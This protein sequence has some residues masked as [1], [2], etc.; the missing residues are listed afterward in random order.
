MALNLQG[1]GFLEV[2]IN[3]RRVPLE[4]MRFQQCLF[5]SHHLFHM[6]M[7]HL[8]FQDTLGILTKVIT[9]ADAVVIR[10][11]I[12]RTRETAKIYDF[13]VFNVQQQP[14]ASGVLY[15]VSFVAPYDR[16]R[17][18]T[19]SEAYSGS[20]YDALQSLAAKCNLRF[21]GDTTQDRQVWL[22]M[23]ETYCKY[24]RRIAATGYADSKSCMLLGLTI[25]GRLRYK[26]LAKIRLDKTVPRITHGVESDIWASGWVSKSKSGFQ[27][28]RGGYRLSTYQFKPSETDTKVEQQ[29]SARRIARNLGINKELK[30]TVGD[31]LKRVLPID[32]G[33]HHPQ[34]QRAWH[35]NKRAVQLLS[36]SGIAVT[37]FATTLDLYDG[38]YFSKYA[39]DSLTGRHLLDQDESGYYVVFGRT[40]FLGSD[41]VYMERFQLT[42]DGHGADNSERTV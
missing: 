10:L 42:R 26:D 21:E 17:L 33:N 36:S 15:T 4:D 35:Q 41:L 32:S 12:G 31:G 23:N 9:P 11:Q 8:V 6:P 30:D 25:D 39:T 34:A 7:G 16:W 3:K 38:V 18:T 14:V 19:V 37:P 22:A 20:S 2:H 29:I 27:N 28:Q 5:G 1:Q 24:A 13:R 40:I